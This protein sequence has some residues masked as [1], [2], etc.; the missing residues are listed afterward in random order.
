MENTSRIK[1]NKKSFLSDIKINVD[2]FI[3]IF[4][5]LSV[6]FIGADLLGVN[7]GVNLR[8]D[9]VLL[10]IFA[11]LLTVK[12]KYRFTFN[13]WIILFA[14]FPLVSIFS[15]VSIKRGILFYFSIAYNII[16][17]FYGF[18]SY[19][20]TYGLAKFIKILRKTCYVQFVLFLL[21]YF[22]K[23]V[24]NYEFS[25]LPTYGFFM[26][27]PRF[28]LWFYEPSYLA[29]YMV[30]WFSI[31]FFMYLL[32]ND[33][34]YFKD[35]IFCALMLILSTSTTGFLGIALVVGIIYIIWLLKSITLRKLIFPFICLILLAVAYFVFNDIFEVFIGRLFNSSLD[36][37]SGGRI[38][39]WEETF[40]VFKDNPL[41]GVGPG[42]YGLYL[43]E[44]A[45]Y[46]PSNVTLEIMATLG[47]FSAIAFYALTL[48]LIVKS[49][50]IYKIEKNSETKLLVACAIGLLIFTI[51]LQ[52]NQGYLRLYHW[53]LFGIIEGGILRY[54]KVKKEKISYV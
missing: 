30:F 54:K 41:F 20:R 4:C 31:S 13:I 7:V 6:L 40:K 42:N 22:L 26:G 48:Q 25:F 52:A 33:K 38:T 15:A 29:N 3:H 9:Q 24:L 34:R 27:I 23:I 44:D 53:M 2:T 16:F 51:I 14:L 43:G 39:G 5:F 12:G 21:Q 47:I 35:I 8:F 50:R 19:V 32:A 17:L 10:F 46:V 37:A 36:E 18:A 45:G 49:V 1:L 11:L 28:R